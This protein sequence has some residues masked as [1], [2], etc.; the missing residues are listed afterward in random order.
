M[1]GAAPGSAG[2]F[3]LAAIPARWALERRDWAAA[4]ALAAPARTT[5]PY[6][7]AITYF[8]RALGAAHTNRLDDARA[9]IAAL[10]E[11]SDR[12]AQAK[13][14]YWAEQVAI[15]HDGA[16]AFLLL[17]EGKRDEARGG[18][19]GGGRARGRDGQER[20]HAGPDRAGARAARRDAARAETAGAR[21]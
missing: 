8:A 15:Q 3:A 7:D 12:L 9:S 21:R 2:I 19:A 14:A 1:T 10:R 4:A 20:R 6:A 16:A 17:A 5:V 18:D 11:I 13:E